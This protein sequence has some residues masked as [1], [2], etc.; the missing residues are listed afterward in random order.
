M[1]RHDYQC[2]VCATVQELIQSIHKPLPETLPC[3]RCGEDSF[4]VFLV[5]PGVITSGMDHKTLDVAIGKD[6]ESRWNRIHE[7]QA[8]RDRVRK[9]SGEQAL[10]RVGKDE[11]EPMKGAKLAAVVTPEPTDN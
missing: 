7:R 3:P 4:Y 2:E 6:A 1:A 5:A 9:D 8:Q 11:Y 10:K